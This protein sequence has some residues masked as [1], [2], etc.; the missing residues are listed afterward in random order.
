MTVL[1]LARL[2]RKLKRFPD[3]AAAHIKAQMEEAAD[4]IV[5]M[6]KRLL[7]K[8]YVD[9]INSI[10]WTWGEVPKGAVVVAK[11]KSKR[12]GNLTL[13]IYA[14]DKKA[15]YARWVEFG[16][17]PHLNGGMFAD[18]QHPGTKAQPYFYVSWRANRNG[19]RRRMRKAIRDSAKKVAASS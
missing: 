13:T 16:T 11:V 7:P 14:G 18:T 8:N 17:P 10:G 19:A 6:M 3:V 2:K 15:F 4:E 5:A 12:G 9:L 1:G